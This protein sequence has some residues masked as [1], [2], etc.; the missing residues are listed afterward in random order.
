[1]VRA[2]CHFIALLHFGLSWIQSG[3]AVVCL[4]LFDVYLS[5]SIYLQCKNESVSD[6]NQTWTATAK[7]KTVGL[8]LLKVLFMLIVFLLASGSILS[9]IASSYPPTGRPISVIQWCLMGLFV[10]ISPQLEGYYPPERW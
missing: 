10:P 5:C 9:A 2:S 7:L 8:Y 4:G 1:M 6:Y 3:L